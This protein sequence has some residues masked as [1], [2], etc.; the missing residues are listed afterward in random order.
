MGNLLIVED[1]PIIRKGLVMWLEKSGFNVSQAEDGKKAIEMIKNNE[2]DLIVLDIMLPFVNGLEV[3]AYIRTNI[4]SWVPVIMLTAKS[5]EDDKILGLDLGADDYMVKPFSNRELEAR[6]RVNLRKKN[7]VDTI[8]NV[9]SRLF[10][11]DHKKYLIS[12]NDKVVELTRKEM[13]LLKILMINGNSFVE[14][15]ELLQNVW[16]YLNSDD[17]R[18]LDIH[19]SKIRKKLYKLG[20]DNIIITKR[21]VGYAYSESDV[22]ILYDK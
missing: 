6:I 14:K 21:G 22:V 2:Y 8:V 9:E 7:Q 17:T 20:I 19:I 4:K 12:R 3:L 15:K 13:D 11:M 5:E 10:N 18:T 1:E 16:G